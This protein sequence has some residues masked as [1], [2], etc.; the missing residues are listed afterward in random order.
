[1]DRPDIVLLHCPQ[2]GEEMD[3]IAGRLQDRLD[4]CGRVECQRSSWRD[5]EIE[6]QRAQEDFEEGMGWR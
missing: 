4:T 6:R 2:C 5:I 1:M 3:F